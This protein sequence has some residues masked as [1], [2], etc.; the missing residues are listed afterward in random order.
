MTSAS[1]GLFSFA[2]IPLEQIPV[3]FYQPLP[4]LRYRIEVVILKR[5]VVEEPEIF[6]YKTRHDIRAFNLGFIHFLISH[7]EVIDIL[8]NRINL[9]NIE[10]SFYMEKIMH[11]A[12]N[13]NPFID[14]LVIA[15][16]LL[17]DFDQL[18]DRLCT[19]HARV[20]LGRINEEGF[21]KTCKAFGDFTHMEV[22]SEE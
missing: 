17:D 1:N 13:R 10:V 15:P 11:E 21:T 3:D 18:Q 4:Y 14:V 7:L 20:D 8:L 16:L 2:E 6:V 12:V 5:V 9:M 19:E 22:R